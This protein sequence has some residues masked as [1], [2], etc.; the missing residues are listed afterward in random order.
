VKL[1]PDGAPRFL[2]SVYMDPGAVGEGKTDGVTF[3]VEATAGGTTRRA[4]VNTAVVEPR[5]LQL[6]LQEFA[7]REVA[8]RLAGDPGPQHL[9]TF[10]WARWSAPHIALRRLV[11]GTASIISPRP[12]AT[13]LASSGR[14][15]CEQTAAHAYRVVT[16]FPGTICLLNGPLQEVAVPCDL[17]KLAFLKSFVSP[18]GLPLTSPRYASA[19]VADCTV[20]G[21]TKHGFSTHPPS[22]GQTRM[23]FPLRLPA[24][25]H[26][27]AATVGLRDGSKSDGCL[28]MVEVTGQEL[29]RKLL[30]PGHWEE[31][32]A[33][34][35]PYAGQEAVL[36]LVTDADV[37]FAYDWGAW[38]EP[39]LE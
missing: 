12:W 10:D 27:F 37:N 28:F 22:R 23:D 17:S 19:A 2:S 21:V 24:G 26:R 9:A 13:A 1:P 33:D 34:L 18:E 32:T 7:G 14:A 31:L 29:A 30:L 4:E 16:T 36:S 5:P 8:L 25:A 20:G 35:A 15:K 11:D 3:S 6:D 38:G 39:R